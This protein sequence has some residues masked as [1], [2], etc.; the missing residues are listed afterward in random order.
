MN[1]QQL[2]ES[3]EYRAYEIDH[4]DRNGLEEVCEVINKGGQLSW[5]LT[6]SRLLG[7]LG[8]N[9]KIFALYFHN[10]I[11]GSIGIKETSINNISGGEIGYLYIEKEHRSFK[12]L[13][14][15]YTAVIGVANKYSFLF[16]ST[17]RDN[18]TINTLMKRNPYM[19][20]AFAAKSPYSS[21]ILF[22]WLCNINSGK[23]TLGDAYELLND[24]FGGEKLE[25]SVGSS[26]FGISF[27]NLE[28]APSQFQGYLRNIINRNQ[29]IHEDD[30]QE[31]FVRVVFGRSGSLPSDKNTIYAGNKFYNKQSQ[32]HML[33]NEVPMIPTFS[34]PEDI[35]G[36]FIAKMK[37]GQKQVGQVFD[38]I[39]D[40]PEDYIFQPKISIDKEFRVLVY[41]MNGKYHV[42]G[43]YQKLGSNVSLK[44][45]STGR[46]FQEASE[47]A[48]KS[49]SK[50][51]Y[52][53]SGV[54]IAITKTEFRE[55]IVGSLASTLGKAYGKL[56]KEDYEGQM[57]LLECNS[58][59]SLSNTMIITDFINSLK[60]NRV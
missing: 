47:I 1:L 54:D 2:L 31:G 18:T 22:Y 6:P 57:V 3:T 37:A 42:S 35:E 15:L 32:Y 29:I 43:V 23:I 20:L 13:S 41:F 40:N 4:S 55:S 17:N 34:N 38:E 39:P 11:V 30:F 27:E 59:P 10:G 7:K 48:L 21:N 44:S 45:I 50:L 26:E 60:S 46:I 52:G 28:S 5:T 9:G 25:E 49:V 8:S 16:A 12:N 36:S 33:S 14:M 24:K 51:G 56:S 53:I 58:M 19:E